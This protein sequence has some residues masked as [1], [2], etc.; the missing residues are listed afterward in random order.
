MLQRHLEHADSPASGGPV[1]P[2]VAAY[3]RAACTRKAAF[4]FSLP[5]D[6]VPRVTALALEML[7]DELNVD[8][9]RLQ[10]ALRNLIIFSRVNKDI[11]AAVRD[12]A[13]RHMQSHVRFYMWPR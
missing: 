3:A 2:L 5:R 1:A 8:G 6:L 9:A 4:K 11:R 7:A 13:T 10:A 12:F